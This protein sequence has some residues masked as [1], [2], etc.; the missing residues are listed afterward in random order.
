MSPTVPGR[1]FGAT[2]PGPRR[3]AVISGPTGGRRCPRYGALLKRGPCVRSSWS[4][5]G[6]FNGT[7]RPGVAREL[8]FKSHFKGEAKFNN[9][10]VEQLDGRS[11]RLSSD[12]SSMFA[13]AM[14]GEH[15]LPGSEPGAGS[16]A[17]RAEM[18]KAVG[19]ASRPGSWKRKQRARSAKMSST[20]LCE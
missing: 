11:Q 18:I 5:S 1:R 12:G 14:G 15:P 13:F 6:S 16:S 20:R 4:R 10:R 3:A 8:P 2:V 17:G 9:G 7:P 19:D